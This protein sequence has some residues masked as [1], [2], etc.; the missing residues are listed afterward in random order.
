MSTYTVQFVF[1]LADDIPGVAELDFRYSGDSTGA[2]AVAERLIPD[3]A[4]LV[5]VDLKETQS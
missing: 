3:C 1:H 4:T 5:S 2:Y